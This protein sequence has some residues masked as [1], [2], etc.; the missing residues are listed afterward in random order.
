MA[1]LTVETD[2]IIRRNPKAVFREFEDGAGV[3]LHLE[4]TAYH[5]VN[6][7]GA[8]IWRLLDTHVT[9]GHL[10]EGIRDSIDDPPESLEEDAAEFLEQLRERDLVE[11]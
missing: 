5:G 10:M 3:L 9:F 7:V 1:E 8:L 6:R 2:A 4:T 11:Y